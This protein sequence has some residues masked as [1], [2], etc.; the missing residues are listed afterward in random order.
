MPRHLFSR[1][2]VAIGLALVVGLAALFVSVTAAA[3]KPS[4]S[5]DSGGISAILDPSDWYLTLPTGHKGDP[6]TVE[7]PKLADFSCSAFHLND[8]KDGVVFTA[9]AGGVTTSGSSYPRSELREMDGSNHA[10]WTN[11]HGT[12][13]LTVR[14]AVTTLP[15]AKPE[16]VTAQIHD[17]NDD[18]LEV[19]LEGSRLTAQYNDGKTEVTLDPHYKLGTAYDLTITASGGRI[20]VDYNGAKKLDI[21]KK[22]SGWYFKSGSYIQSNTSKGDK[23]SAVA[24]VVIYR[25]A[26]KHSG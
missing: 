9:N 12:H 21:A 1:P 3:G 24:V 10:S 20:R 18:V 17:A 11:T 15:K 6:D 25:L 16:V 5:S 19:R 7:M 14:Q 22:G 23:A 13:T 26:V 8:G 4:R 2:A